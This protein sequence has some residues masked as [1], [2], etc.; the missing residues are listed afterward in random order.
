MRYTADTAEMPLIRTMKGKCFLSLLKRTACLGLAL[1]ALSATVLT[2]NSCGG[3]EGDDHRGTITYRQFLGGSKLIYLQAG[4]GMVLRCDPDMMASGTQS[5]GYAYPAYLGINV[6][7]GPE[8]QASFIGLAEHKNDDAP[9]H[10]SVTFYVGYA[11]HTYSKDTGF[12]AFLGFPGSISPQ[13]QL[14]APLQLTLDFDAHTW[15][16]R[17]PDG[18]SLKWDNNATNHTFVFGDTGGNMSSSDTL[19]EQER[20]GTFDIMSF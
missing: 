17:I 13:L 15:K 9:M 10:G 2:L 5:W 1:F 7:P 16:T 14:A 11:G 18:S 19:I 12:T 3:G 8:F 4:S 20:T 6:A